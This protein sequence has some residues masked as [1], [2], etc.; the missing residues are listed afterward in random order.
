MA[1]VTKP[2]I[3]DGTGQ[4]IKQKLSE[5]LAALQSSGGSY[6]P[7]SQKGAASGVAELDANGK[8]PS[9]QLPSYV[10]DVLEYASTSAFPAT[11]ETGKIYVALD[12]NLTY[13]WSG[14][15][16]VEISPSLALGETSSTAY[17]GDR[18]KTA[19][20]HATESGKI[21]AAVA[22]GLYKIAATAQGHIAGLTAVQ[23]SDLT[24][25]GV[26]DANNIPT[27]TDTYD[28]TS[29][30]GM[31]GKAVKSAI[32]ALDVTTSGAGASKTLTA[33][34]QTDG[35]ISATFGNISITK[36]Q[37][38][39]FPTI[40]TVNNS[41]I[42]I[43]KNGTTVDSFTLNQ[44][45][46][47]DID[48]SVPTKT[49]DLT[50]DS[51]YK[52][53]DAYITCDSVKPTS[54]T[55]Y[56][57]TFVP[58]ASW[59]SNQ[60][61]KINSYF[62]FYLRNGTTSVNGYNYLQLGN[63]TASGTADNQYGVLRIFS[64]TAYRVDLI[65]ATDLTANRDIYLPDKAGTIALTTDTMTPA[66]HTHGNIQNGGTLQTT[67]V[68]IASGDKLVICDSS[69]SNK[70]ARSS[71]AFTSNT[72]KFLREDGTWQTVSVSWS[73]GT[74]SQN[75]LPNTDITLN[76]GSVD[77]KFAGL[78]AGSLIL[79]KASTHNGAIQLFSSSHSYE[80]IIYPSTSL[81][82]QAFFRLPS[83]G[84]TL[85]TQETTVKFKY[86]DLSAAVSCAANATT[87]II[88]GFTGGIPIC[89][90]IDNYNNA[91]INNLI[92]FCAKWYSSYNIDVR[93]VSGSA[94]TI[95]A[96]TRVYIGYV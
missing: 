73:G 32:D 38:S 22:S 66:S 80:S 86:I 33:L 56:Y 64:R 7:T 49:S 68:A 29:S 44:S 94:V 85:A 82:A 95:A 4:T 55:G 70:I 91:G 6:I 79:G 14:S 89:A 84:G 26:A 1:N 27:I 21:S 96:N 69:D 20:D 34:S 36:S 43:K 15:A 61:P 77:K 16:Y 59:S 25:L 11:G 30:D 63:S 47:K 42:T 5:I 18:G 75:I 72:S 81:T 45:S 57:P 40:P 71:L 13:R 12:T 83:T 54:E 52:T 92:P 53:T 10:D 90:Y 9:S 50:N 87:A 48:I 8:V 17:R 65:A 60:K 2:P 78:Y 24:A 37:I 88:T 62:K 19:Y 93:N 41:T 76:I 31:S 28:G 35:K 3:L 23:K 46:A 74:V 51:G 67:D 39:D 58:A